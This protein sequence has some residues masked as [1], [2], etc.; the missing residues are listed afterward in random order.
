MKRLLLA[1]TALTA[2]A[3]MPAALADDSS[4]VLD[5]GGI[6]LTK[7][8]DIR[9]ASEDL[10]LSPKSVKVHYTFVN[11][12]GKDIDTIVAFPLPDIDN[13]EFAESP[14]GTTT[15]STPNF[16]GFKLLVDGKPVTTTPEER[17]M[18]N[19]KDVTGMVK[20]AGLP[21]NIVIQD[22]AYDKLQKLPKPVHDRLAKAGLIEGAGGDDVVHA[23]WKVTTK[24]WWKMHFP[25]GKTVTVDHSY[26]PVT[27]QSFFSDGEINTPSPDYDN[28]KLYCIDAGTRATILGAIKET[29]TKDMPNGSLLN[30]FRTDFVIVTAN[31]WKG[32][33]GKFHLTIDKLKPSN[34]LSLCWSGD[35]KKTGATT[36]E[37]TLTDFAPKQDVKILVLEKPV[38]QKE[39]GY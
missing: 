9:M 37:S 34:I 15:Q 5:A 2:L 6:V 26:T 27:G 36:F 38:P 24:F 13:Y 29:A 25:A 4:A 30:A 21:L 10:F 16:V 18:L 35:L 33:I 39:G 32:P 23:K 17:A 28:T 22:G 14:I 12:S 31:N 11:D 19:G 7:N 1:A 8:A 3:L 20:A